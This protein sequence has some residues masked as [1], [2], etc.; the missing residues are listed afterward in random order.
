MK[1][2]VSKLKPK[3]FYDDDG[4]QE[5]VMLT[6]K[7]FDMLIDELQELYDYHMVL[8]VKDEPTYSSEEVG[9]RIEARKD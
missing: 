1:S 4:K 9:A 5:G 6:E 8:K 7:Q 3:Y 2:V